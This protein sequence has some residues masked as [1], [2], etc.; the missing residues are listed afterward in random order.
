MELQNSS[1]SLPVLNSLLCAFSSQCEQLW[2]DAQTLSQ[3]KRRTDSLEKGTWQQKTVDTKVT[4][5]C[6]N[7]TKPLSADF[8]YTINE[9]KNLIFDE[10]TDTLKLIRHYTDDL[11]PSAKLSVYSSQIDLHMH[12]NEVGS[13]MFKSITWTSQSQDGKDT[14]QI[15]S[16]TR[17]FDQTEIQTLLLHTLSLLSNERMQNHSLWT[18]FNLFQNRQLSNTF[19]AK[20]DNSPHFF[21]RNT[22]RS[23]AK[24]FLTCLSLSAFSYPFSQIN[25]Q[26]TDT[27]FFD[28]PHS[29]LLSLAITSTPNSS[30]WMTT[31][32]PSL[33]LFF[34]QTGKTLGVT[35]NDNI[36][37]VLS[38][39]EYLLSCFITSLSSFS[40]TLALFPQQPQGFSPTEKDELEILE[41]LGIHTF[42]STVLFNPTFVKALTTQEQ[43]Q[44]HAELSYLSQEYLLGLLC[45][46]IDP[47]L[48]PLHT[49]PLSVAVTIAVHI[50]HRLTS[51]LCCQFNALSTTLFSILSDTL[52]YSHV[53]CQSLDAE[54]ADMSLSSHL[55]SILVSHSFQA[56]VNS[57][58]PSLFQLM[59]SS[60][61]QKI[62][63]ITFS[64]FPSS[65]IFSS[66]SL[67]PL[68][69]VLSSFFGVHSNASFHS[70]NSSIS[71][72]IATGALPQPLLSSLLKDQ[73]AEWSHGQ[74][75]NILSSFL[76]VYVAEMLKQGW[77]DQR[78]ICTQIEHKLNREAEE[79]FKQK[80][81]NE[82]RMNQKSVMARRQSLSQ[83]RDAEII[84]RS[85]N[86]RQLNHDLFMEFSKVVLSICGDNLTSSFAMSFV[87]VLLLHLL[88]R[89]AFLTSTEIDRTD[90]EEDQKNRQQWKQA[91]KV[92]DKSGKQ[93][94]KDSSQSEENARINSRKETLLSM[95]CGLIELKPDILDGLI[96][97]CA[98]TF[99]LFSQMTESA[100]AKTDH[101]TATTDFGATLQLYQQNLSK[102]WDVFSLFLLDSTR[103]VQQFDPVAF[104]PSYPLLILLVLRTLRE[105]TSTL[106]WTPKTQTVDS[107]VDFVTNKFSFIPS[108]VSLFKSLPFSIA[109][110]TLS[111][112]RFDTHTIPSDSASTLLVPAH[113]QSRLFL[114]LINSA[115]MQNYSDEQAFIAKQGSPDTPSKASPPKIFSTIPIST[116]TF[117]TFESPVANS[118]QFYSWI[119]NVTSLFNDAAYPLGMFI[120]SGKFENFG[121]F[122]MALSSIKRALSRFEGATLEGELDEDQVEK[123]SF[124][125]PHRSPRLDVVS[126]PKPN[127]PPR[128]I[129]A[130]EVVSDGNTQTQSTAEAE[131][132]QP[133][134]LSEDQQEPP[135][136]EQAEQSV[137][138]QPSTEEPQPSTEEPQ[139]STEQ[140]A[141][142]GTDTHQTD[143]YQSYSDPYNPSQTDYYGTQQNQEYSGY[144]QDQP[145]GYGQNQSY[146][147][148]NSGY[149]YDQS[150][151]QSQGGYGDNQEGYGHDSSGYG[152]Q[153]SGYY[154][155]GNDSEV[156]QSYANDNT[157]QY[158]YD[159]TQSYQNE[160][161]EYY[162][163]Q[164]QQYQD[165]QNQPIEEEAAL[166]LEDEQNQVS[167][168]AEE[169]QE[170]P[171]GS[172]ENG[173][174]AQSVTLPENQTHTLPT[175][176]PSG[177]PSFSPSHTKSNN[178][179]L[180][181][182]ATVDGFRSYLSEQDTKS[183]GFKP[184]SLFTSLLHFSSLMM[185]IPRVPKNEKNAANE[186]AQ[187]LSKSLSLV[188]SASCLPSIDPFTLHLKSIQRHT[189]QLL[190]GGTPLL[191]LRFYRLL[192][193]TI[194]FHPCFANNTSFLNYSQSLEKFPLF[195]PQPLS[196]FVSFLA[197]TVNTIQTLTQAFPSFSN[198]FT[199]PNPLSDS[200]TQ[201]DLITKSVPFNPKLKPAMNPLLNS[202]FATHATLSSFKQ[203]PSA[204]L[205]ENDHTT[206]LSIVPE[207]PQF[208][209]T[210]SAVP[211]LYPFKNHSL[212]PLFLSMTTS[213]QNWHTNPF[214]LSL[215]DS[216]CLPLL[217][218]P[219]QN[220]AT[221][222]VF[223]VI[224]QIFFDSFPQHLLTVEK[225][226]KDIDKRNKKE[227]KPEGQYPPD[228]IFLFDHL[229]NKEWKWLKELSES[230]PCLLLS[231][232]RIVLDSTAKSKEKKLSWFAEGPVL[233]TMISLVVNTEPRSPLF[234]TILSDTLTVISLA[235]SPAHTLLTTA[236]KQQK[237]NRTREYLEKANEQIQSIENEVIQFTTRLQTDTQNKEMFERVK[238]ALI[239]QKGFVIG[240]DDF[241]K[242]STTNRT[243]RKIEHMY[244]TPRTLLVG[245][246]PSLIDFLLRPTVPPTHPQNDKDELESMT[247]ILRSLIPPYVNI[248]GLTK[249]ALHTLKTFLT[250]PSTKVTNNMPISFSF[251]SSFILL[252]TIQL[253]DPEQRSIA[254][255]HLEQFV[256]TEAQKLSH[257]YMN[258]T[259]DE[260]EYNVI[261]NEK[262][263]SMMNVTVKS[264]V[265]NTPFYATPTF[266]SN[267]IRT[268][269]TAAV[270]SYHVF[271]LSSEDAFIPSTIEEVDASLRAHSSVMNSLATEYFQTGES[272]DK[273][274]PKHSSLERDLAFLHN[275]T[276]VYRRTK[277]KNTETVKCT[278]K[279]GTGSGDDV[280]VSLFAQKCN[281]MN[282]ITGLIPITSYD[283]ARGQ[284][285]Q[286]LLAERNE[287]IVKA[288]EI[289]SPFYLHISTLIYQLKRTASILNSFIT[290]QAPPTDGGYQNENDQAE[291]LSQQAITLTQNWVVYMIQ[292]FSEFLNQSAS[293]EH[294]P[295]KFDPF[296]INL[297]DPDNN[298][299]QQFLSTTVNSDGSMTLIVTL[300]NVTLRTLLSLLPATYTLQNE[301]VTAIVA[302][303]LLVPYLKDFL[304]PSILTLSEW[305]ALYDSAFNGITYHLT[306]NNLQ[307]ELSF[308]ISETTKD[309]LLQLHAT[310]LISPLNRI[311]RCFSL[312]VNDIQTNLAWSAS[313]NPH[314]LLFN[315]TGYAPSSGYSDPGSEAVQSPLLSIQYAQHSSYSTFLDPLLGVL[316]SQLLYLF[317][318]NADKFT[319]VVLTGQHMALEDDES[320]ERL[321]QTSSDFL[322]ED[323]MIPLPI[324]KIAQTD[325]LSASAELI[326]KVFKELFSLPHADEHLTSEVVLSSREI[327]QST[328]ITGTGFPVILPL[329][330]PQFLPS[331][332][333]QLWIDLIEAASLC[334]IRSQA[335]L[336]H[337]SD[338]TQEED[339]EPAFPSKQEQISK[340]TGF[341]QHGLYPFNESV[342]RTLMEAINSFPTVAVSQ[343][344]ATITTLPQ[345]PSLLNR[346][347]PQN[348]QPFAFHHIGP[349]SP[350][351]SLVYGLNV[352][353]ETMAMLRWEKDQQGYI[354]SD[355]CLLPFSPESVAEIE[356]VRLAQSDTPITLGKATPFS[357]RTLLAM[358]SFVKSMILRLVDF[359]PSD[360]ST[361]DSRPRSSNQPYSTI[362][363][364]TLVS[365]LLLL[366]LALSFYCS[367]LSPQPSSYLLAG[368]DL[369]HFPSVLYILA[370]CFHEQSLS[371][372]M[373]S[374]ITALFADLTTTVSAVLRK[375]KEIDEKETALRLEA[376]M[377][378]FRQK[379]MQIT[380]KN[381]A[382][383]SQRL[384]AQAEEDR[385]REQLH[386]WRSQIKEYN[387]GQ[388]TGTADT[389]Q[390]LSSPH[391]TT[392][393]FM[394]SC[395][396]QTYSSMVKATQQESMKAMQGA[397][398]SSV[399]LFTTSFYSQLPWNLNNHTPLAFTRVLS[400]TILEEQ[401]LLKTSRSFFPL[402][403]Y[404]TLQMDWN[405]VVNGVEPNVEH[406]EL[407]LEMDG[408]GRPSDRVLSTPIVFDPFIYHKDDLRSATEATQDN[409]PTG[410]LVKE[411]FDISYDGLG[412]RT[413]QK[414]DQ[415][416]SDELSRLLVLSGM[417][418]METY[419]CGSSL[420][421]DL[422]PSIPTHLSSLSM[423]PFDI[424]TTERL[425]S[426]VSQ[427][428]QNISATYT[429]PSFPSDSLFYLPSIQPFASEPSAT[430]SFTSA[431]HISNL[432]LVLTS[433]ILVASSVPHTSS[434][435]ALIN[436]K[437]S[438]RRPSSYTS[439]ESQ[440]PS[441]I[442]ADQHEWKFE[443]LLRQSEEK[444]AR[445]S[446]D[447]TEFICA[448]DMCRFRV[449]TTTI[450]SLLSIT[451]TPCLKQ[452]SSPSF[453]TNPLNL[454]PTPSSINAI[455]VL[456]FDLLC[457]IDFVATFQIH[458]THDRQSLQSQTQ[459][460]QIFSHLT[461][462]LNSFVN[463]FVG[464]QRSSGTSYP[465]IISLH[466]VTILTGLVHIL[467]I[468]QHTRTALA[469]I[470]TPNI[471]I[472]TAAPVQQAP[473]QIKQAPEPKRKG[474]EDN[475]K[476][477][478]DA[479]FS[480]M[481]ASAPKTQV[482]AP[483]RQAVSG[484]A[485]TTFPTTLFIENSLL[486]AILLVIPSAASARST[487]PSDTQLSTTLFLFELLMSF[488]LE[489]SYP[490]LPQ[491]LFPTTLN[492]DE[493]HPN[494]R[495]SQIIMAHATAQFLSEHSL[496]QQQSLHID[497]LSTILST[498][499]QLIFTSEPPQIGLS[500][501]RTVERQ[502]RMVRSFYQDCATISTDSAFYLFL[503][504]VAS[505]LSI[506]FMPTKLSL[507]SPTVPDSFFEGPSSRSPCLCLQ[508]FDSLIQSALVSRPE[509][510]KSSGSSVPS[511]YSLASAII[512]TNSGA[513]K[514]L[515]PPPQN[516][517]PSSAP[518]RE[519]EAICLLAHISEFIIRNSSLAALNSDIDA[520]VANL[521]E[522]VEG[523]WFWE[524]KALMSDRT[525]ACFGIAVLCMSR[526]W[527]GERKNAVTKT[528]YK[529]LY[530]S[531]SSSLITLS[532]Q[533]QN[534]DFRMYV[535]GAIQN[536][537][538]AALKI[539]EICAILVNSNVNIA[540]RTPSLL[541]PHPNEQ[542]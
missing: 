326:L 249:T 116:Y 322:P 114:A 119:A 437:Q 91:S 303:T 436:D 346:H 372:S 234:G 528:D 482:Q 540:P 100:S 379:Q 53:H 477:I 349:L 13:G 348:P 319:N 498:I 29:R 363:S 459:P 533:R 336:L 174:P 356:T 508:S 137:D 31:F 523:K 262:E 315:P 207:L 39:T 219:S 404:I 93:Q 383:D 388:M 97:F 9:F 353:C 35:D 60:S 367:L 472:E 161:Q 145:D 307:Q 281:T 37:L 428:M 451:F 7:C 393:G 271:T 440:T 405:I 542:R 64:S 400:K 233:Q 204:Y 306:T 36:G 430:F 272:D 313:Q 409:T 49:S 11:I 221:Q 46:T 179:F 68:S 17:Q 120:R 500:A 127:T 362:D 133:R 239:Q 335:G 201:T 126:T 191:V 509:F 45:A 539:D 333:E 199:S 401:S 421:K 110:C 300:F 284:Q 527:K 513:F 82:D 26:Q 96:S 487:N 248:V 232:D 263:Q 364:T 139:P 361:F 56:L 77:S 209:S 175:P 255:Q 260:N 250:T 134:P 314:S 360:I 530:K 48:P 466:R 254:E 425:F 12:I 345:H 377:E 176:S 458:Q 378:M 323:F 205:S 424:L 103:C 442:L 374:L 268:Q 69:V 88:H 501:S 496:S 275:L 532:K 297:F 190:N 357:I 141:Y 107:L 497:D 144:Y 170:Q 431:T 257:K 410:Q 296:L 331:V 164:E 308:L 418:M 72:F 373:H 384:L 343:L 4:H 5:A 59:F 366:Q 171:E 159:S 189:E 30:E 305:S 534:T 413:N 162:G 301:L 370:S 382:H 423:V 332:G 493:L 286:S 537:E 183:S 118:R 462:I 244:V 187:P 10:L 16:L 41:T 150:Q 320:P 478:L 483:P 32:L 504:T 389:T 235:S 15:P 215:I 76:S 411:E 109:H 267:P 95:L 522:I 70:I 408:T 492:S 173:E 74:R 461:F 38:V 392:L 494:Q 368:S 511:A 25:S 467:Q 445:F 397:L 381:K 225:R 73:T 312:P 229:V 321:G 184:T 105:R 111:M 325:R 327:G 123:D 535:E 446:T 79:E 298:T 433:L 510:P 197:A 245:S 124:P 452:T 359:I 269:V 443:D 165:T 138:D 210:P 521:F 89:H 213:V 449:I 420:L 273:Q 341:E 339:T 142:Y 435:M 224:E 121:D 390:L 491:S 302:N 108:N 246:K 481:P 94:G 287:A 85:A 529:K 1:A 266:K 541:D 151:N 279:L 407:S 474:T 156:N 480:D 40:A 338:P 469:K 236:I 152:Y 507:T 203:L 117:T 125:T 81:I 270:V 195:A 58:S 222:S 212:L 464:S 243:I 334:L 427:T 22:I 214:W 228:F 416:L 200:T 415:V 178:P 163:Q 453:K 67:P 340:E 101:K 439:P 294:S 484:K 27:P 488:L 92:T 155:G 130:P 489:V 434:F 28:L 419:S 391:S 55:F 132:E 154:Q 264:L 438:I 63:P 61:T 285:I 277:V 115:L 252:H 136:Q 211:P 160:G 536:L 6:T 220:N 208:G 19:Q 166:P 54:K 202:F 66:L 258:R 490:A 230:A 380:Q 495:G 188:D 106:N 18:Q 479:F 429:L 206:L 128:E 402:I 256:K 186:E 375:Q 403:P 352:L 282:E 517:P 417:S 240:S 470:K 329:S 441:A 278:H 351:H 412:N 42:L 84:E 473:Q 505:S 448:L 112:L 394:F 406:E 369:A 83:Q 316:F 486:T 196:S 3:L 450:I 153:Q 87:P 526:K 444:T 261:L 485:H 104:L 463:V 185:S 259:S 499:I 52:F 358:S 283:S 311:L 43:L 177:S 90:Q 218:N 519:T 231:L 524:K 147:Y 167:G 71:S 157:Q 318:H 62:T 193:S 503:T 274:K 2:N 288:T 471:I 131:D 135:R 181:G 304:T 122:Q 337:P 299:N 98:H 447:R 253:F 78:L 251:T 291:A 129:T 531:V 172:V 387:L 24:Q 426:V 354:V 516:S 514:L 247:F 227:G 386:S 385:K 47:S 520:F 347:S 371:H 34:T 376:S 75:S 457:S 180:D 182:K 468:G 265:N 238:R 102:E 290:K 280:S 223:Q 276:H 502:G 149:G 350:S 414:I 538:P 217:F 237:I 454:F 293:S 242:Q 99:D 460:D 295:F 395:L 518:L 355:H 33:S 23:L 455:L 168:G 456:A 330:L 226:K 342:W 143:S 506:L 20:I 432:C 465:S 65:A 309:T 51:S 140:D 216:I 512:S 396:F 8:R 525:R 328:P 476:S 292:Q 324:K 146:D 192:L 399:S 50:S 14:T 44:E 169:V 241:Q 475:T 148:G 21:A 344:S 57:C 365:P 198:Y 113:T 398:I 422:S 86:N 194:Q 310:S 515:A 80:A 317:S 158:G 289:T